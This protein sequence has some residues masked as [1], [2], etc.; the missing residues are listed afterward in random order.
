[1][2]ACALCYV[3]CARLECLTPHPVKQKAHRWRRWRKC[4]GEEKDLFSISLQVMF[5][6]LLASVCQKFIV[7]LSPRGMLTPQFETTCINKV[8]Q[9]LAL[10]TGTP[11]GHNI[12]T[13]PTEEVNDRT[14]LNK[15]LPAVLCS[16]VRF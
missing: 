2:C 14:S 12:R 6:V 7:S 9:T 10:L 16:S 15:V 5:S 13:P 11:I 8:F 3:L 1:M 4:E